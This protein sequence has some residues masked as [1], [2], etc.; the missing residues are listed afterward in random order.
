MPPGDAGANDTGVDAGDGG[1]ADAVP[2]EAAVPNGA[3]ST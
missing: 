2:V 3:A 1:A